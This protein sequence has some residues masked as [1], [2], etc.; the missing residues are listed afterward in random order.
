MMNPLEKQVQQLLDQDDNTNKKEDE[1]FFRLDVDKELIRHA[2]GESFASE[3]ITEWSMNHFDRTQVLTTREELLHFSRFLNSYA[4][5]EDLSKPLHFQL[6]QVEET[7]DKDQA[8]V[9][10]C[11]SLQAYQP[12]KPRGPLCFRRFKYSWSMMVQT[13]RI[14]ST[15]K[16]TIPKTCHSPCMNRMQAKVQRW[17]DHHDEWHYQYGPTRPHWYLH[18]FGVHPNYKGQGRGKSIMNKLCQLAD[19]L[20]QDIYLECGGTFLKRFYEKFGFVVMGLEPLVDPEDTTSTIE[21]YLMVREASNF[22]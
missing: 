12:H 15:Y 19:Q 21:V 11:A 16:E 20:D 3:P 6:C 7:D 2:L 14:M 1:D 8:V 9:I 5:L 4:L 13:V 10:S 22:P 17:V 18:L